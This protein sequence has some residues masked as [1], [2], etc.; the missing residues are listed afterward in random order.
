MRFVRQLT[1]STLLLTLLAAPVY[2]QTF[3]RV[4]DILSTVFG[5]IFGAFVTA[6]EIWM[7][8]I[9]VLIAF[10][11]FWGLL[12]KVGFLDD[13]KNARILLSLAI[14]VGAVA[15]IPNELMIAIFGA[16]GFFGVVLFVAPM[17]GLMYLTYHLTHEE[18]TRFKYGAMLIIW[19]LALFIYVGPVGNVSAFSSAL[20]ASLW[21]TIL[22]FVYIVWLIIRMFSVGG[23][24]Q[25]AEEVTEEKQEAAE[26]KAATRRPAPRNLAS[27]E[28]TRLAAYGELNDIRTSRSRA[29][30]LVGNL[31][32]TPGDQ[33]RKT[34][35][36]NELRTLRN[37]ISDMENQLGKI[38]SN[39]AVMKY[40][41][42]S[43]SAGTVGREATRAGWFGI[44]G[45][46]RRG[47]GIGTGSGML[48][49]V[50]TRAAGDIEWLQEQET[51]LRAPGDAAVDDLRS[52][53]DEMDTVY[54]PGGETER[55]LTTLQKD[56]VPT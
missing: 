15:P 36:A 41:R 11:L 27:A 30:S 31:T 26:H 18:P 4:G 43:G 13:H 49:D 14:S 34:A 39:R 42:L 40:L 28:R 52:R 47:T 16:F 33:P 53:L 54:G 20:E 23:A 9:F 29:M 2:A 6:P 12:G 17:I 1:L 35:L 25:T 55:M 19:V 50:F 56:F 51:A 8:V 7:K 46:L 48:H 37:G 10:S 21:L 22:C 32:P 24:G 38:E 44:G 5:G 45:A 3:G